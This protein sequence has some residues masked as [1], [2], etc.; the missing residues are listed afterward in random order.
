MWPLALSVRATRSSKQ[1]AEL[2]RFD[3]K[4]VV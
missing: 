2:Y 1:I 3:Y 4:P